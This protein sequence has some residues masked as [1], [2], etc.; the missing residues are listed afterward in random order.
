MEYL[1]HTCNTTSVM[2]NHNPFIFKHI[3]VA[4]MCTFLLVSCSQ[5]TLPPEL[6]GTWES[7]TIDITVRTRTA[8][9]EW[10]FTSEKVKISVTIHADQRVTG[11]IGAANIENGKIRKNLGNPETTGCSEIIECGSIG[12]IFENDPVDAKEVELWLAPMKEGT[13][14]TELRFTEGWAQFPMAG[15][16]LKKVGD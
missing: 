11:S 4:V 8:D 14:D 10:V 2:K 12:K 6:I 13:I 9:K 1:T 16:L 7:E 5:W 15:F 3:C